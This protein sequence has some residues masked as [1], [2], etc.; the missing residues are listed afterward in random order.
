MLL[1]ESQDVDLMFSENSYLLPCL[2]W[3]FLDSRDRPVYQIEVENR[4][5][6]SDSVRKVFYQPTIDKTR[7][8]FHATDIQARKQ[9]L[10]D[11]TRQKQLLME[12]AVQWQR[13]EIGGGFKQAQSPLRTHRSL[14]RSH[15]EMADASTPPLHQPV[16]GTCATMGAT[17]VTYPHA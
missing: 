9:L 12:N 1:I 8:L 4:N 16:P 11:L 17:P 2:P 14:S 13:W 6:S 3:T 10:S 7:S 15:E 5:V